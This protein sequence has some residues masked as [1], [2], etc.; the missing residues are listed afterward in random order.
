MSRRSDE[1]RAMREPD[2]IRRAEDEQIARIHNIFII[3]TLL[4]TALFFAWL[5]WR[6]Y[7]QPIGQRAAYLEGRYD[8]DPATA[9]DYAAGRYGKSSGE[10][11]ASK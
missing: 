3:V 10:L 6:S 9:M 11:R 1:V 5:G 8:L 7:R 2:A 4:L